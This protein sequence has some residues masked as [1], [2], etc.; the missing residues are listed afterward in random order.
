M[1]GAYGMADYVELFHERFRWDTNWKVLAEN[2]M[3]SYHLP[4]CHAGTIGGTVAARGDGLPAGP[5]RLQLALDPQE[6]RGAAGARAPA[7]TT[8]CRAT[9]GGGPG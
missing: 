6:R 2:F 9:T 5:A 3:E 8:A 7:A 1:I 4:V